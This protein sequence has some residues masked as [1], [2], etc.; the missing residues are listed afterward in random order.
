MV[1]PLFKA[2][3]AVLVGTPLAVTL[4]LTA[5]SIAKQ[6]DAA[7]PVVDPAVAPLIVTVF[8]NW[9]DVKTHQHLAP[10]SLKKGYAA[11]DV[12]VEN[13]TGSPVKGVHVELIDPDDDVLGTV[14]LGEVDAHGHSVFAAKRSWNRTLERIRQSESTPRAV[15]TWKA[16]VGRQRVIA[17]VFV[18]RV[19]GPTPSE[20]RRARREKAPVTAQVM[21]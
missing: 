20:L 4:G 5:R 16:G 21:S 9:L 8:S 14:R 12:R 17:P 15:V 10:T 13:R 3:G 19:L 6:E 11:Y 2:I 1:A 18:R 7:V